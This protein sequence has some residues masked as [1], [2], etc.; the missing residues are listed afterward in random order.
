MAGALVNDSDMMRKCF[1]FLVN[2]EKIP[3]TENFEHFMLPEKFAEEDMLRFYN[4]Q[5]YY[6][7]KAEEKAYNLK[8]FQEKISVNTQQ[9]VDLVW[10]NIL[11]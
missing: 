3:A 11:P 9:V 7:K 8:K 10:F 2:T 4:K 5:G 1:L 6:G